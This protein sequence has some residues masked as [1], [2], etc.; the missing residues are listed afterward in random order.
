MMLLLRAPE[1]HK[2][3]A[4][5]LCHLQVHLVLHTL[6]VFD[7]H[8]HVTPTGKTAWEMKRPHTRLLTTTNAPTVEEAKSR[9]SCPSA[10]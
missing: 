6:R 8:G 1:P 5:R 9:T 2:P 4:W 3:Q 10:A 7:R